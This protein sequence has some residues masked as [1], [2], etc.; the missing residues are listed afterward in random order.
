[1]KLIF[2]RSAPGR[3]AYHL[4]ELDVPEADTAITLPAS[5]IRREKPALPEVSEGEIVRHYL[6]LSHRNHSVDSGFYPLGSCTMKYNPKLN[7]EVAALSGFANL[8]ILGATSED[9]CEY[10]ERGLLAPGIDYETP[11]PYLEEIC[12]PLDSEG[13]VQ[14]PQEPGMGYN[15]NW[16]YIEENIITS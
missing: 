13:Y 2:E 1:M 5:V 9:T 12:D 16:D 11:P 14:V 7:E 4:P 3:R 8:Q 10:Y 6:N 15:I